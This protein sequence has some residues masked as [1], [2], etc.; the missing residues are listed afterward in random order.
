[1]VNQEYGYVE[2]GPKL[3]MKLEGVGN[4]APL[5]THAAEFP[6]TEQLTTRSAA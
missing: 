4:A 5:C 1:M 6:E 2:T 3:A